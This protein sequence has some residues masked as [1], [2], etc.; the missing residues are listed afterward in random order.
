MNLLQRLKPE[1]LKRLNQKTEEHQDLVLKTLETLE[2]ECYVS[3]LRYCVIL[4]LQ[5]LLSTPTL[6]AFTFFRDDL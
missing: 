2:N 1:Y 5:Y 4:D 6:N 3:Q